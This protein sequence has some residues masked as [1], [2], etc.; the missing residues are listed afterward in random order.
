M[1][2]IVV[3][4]SSQLQSV[5]SQLETL[6]KQFESK[7]GEL[8]AEQKKLDGMWDGA[9][10]TEF[11]NMFNKDKK[12]FDTFHDTIKDYIEKLKTIKKNYEDTETRNAQIA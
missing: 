10:N 5:I 11:N 6:N 3:K 4:S 12:Q 9:A 7:V 8:V 1:K 2:E